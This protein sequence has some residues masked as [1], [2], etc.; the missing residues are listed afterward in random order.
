MTLWK[1][2]FSLSGRPSRW[3]YDEGVVLKGIY[4]CWLRTGNEDYFHYIQR[5]M[6]FFVG[7]DGQIRTYE[8]KEYNLDNINTGRI[9]LLLYKKTG[10]QQYRQA[11]SLLREQL[12]SQPRTASGG[13]WHKKVYPYQM[14]LDGLYMA[15][16]F[17]TQYAAMFHEDT[18][19]NDV[20][21]QFREMELHSRD[22]RTGLLYHGWDES[23]SQRWADPQTG[24]SPQFWG[25]AMGWYGIALV[26]ALEYFPA[27]HPGRK[28]LTHILNRYAAAIAS[29]QDKA[30]GCWWDILD[31]PGRDSNYLEASA[32][33]MF[34][35]ALAKGVRLG[36]L[37][38]VYLAIA[39][40]GYKGMI[41]QFVET[42][43]DG[44]VH[45]KGTVTVSG[46]GGNPYRDGSFAY[47]MSEKVITDDPKGMGAFI[48]AACEAEKLL[49]R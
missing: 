47:Y 13:F 2:S 36:L 43:A 23:R 42:A 31:A 10:Q 38:P 22:P 17:Y 11:A 20:A 32:S 14:W 33:S 44:Q 3:S 24:H 19:F 27:K 5:S 49:R 45:L 37:P 1:D 18:A 8:C 40:K 21:R 48:Q 15:E 16:P 29:V 25:R 28:E 30:S 6:D 46:L 41:R 26:D 12:R 4:D 9:L 35:Y 39:Q 34:V 7:K